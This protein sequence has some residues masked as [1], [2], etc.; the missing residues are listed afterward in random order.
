MLATHDLDVAER[1]VDRVVVLKDGRLVADEASPA[2][3]R[4]RYRTYVG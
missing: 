1:L 2:E 4:Q 3:L